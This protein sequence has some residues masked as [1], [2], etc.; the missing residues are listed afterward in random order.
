L[1]GALIGLFTSLGRARR[2]VIV[3][4]KTLIA[5]GAAAFIAGLAA[6][7]W[8]Q[9]RSVIYPLLLAGFI[10]STVP[11]GLLPTIRRRYEE[12]ELRTMRA[13]DVG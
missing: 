3:A 1:V 2:F 5:L 11:L 6:S 13:H 8:S 9:P 4:A 12:I 10:A 7:A